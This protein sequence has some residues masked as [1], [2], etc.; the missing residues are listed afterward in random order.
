MSTVKLKVGKIIQSTPAFIGIRRDIVIDAL[1]LQHMLKKAMP[2][3]GK[4]RLLG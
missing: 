1:V 4:Q 3:V 2:F